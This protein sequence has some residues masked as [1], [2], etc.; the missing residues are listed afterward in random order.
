MKVN[1]FNFA[2]SQCLKIPQN[3]AFEIFDFWHFSSI[4]V[5]LKLT[6]LETLF[7]RKLPVFKN[8]PKMTIFGI[9]KQLLST[10][11]V[12][13]TRLACNVK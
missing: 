8:S 13:V 2:L 4:F 1:Q 7:D 3:V 12:N 10:Q 6:C 9:F 11:N 5:L